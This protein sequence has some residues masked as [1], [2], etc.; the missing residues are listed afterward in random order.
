[1]YLPIVNVVTLSR[2]VRRLFPY[3]GPAVEDIVR[4]LLQTQAVNLR[5]CVG[6]GKT[7][8]GLLSAMIVMV[9][10]RRIDRILFLA[11]TNG[12]V[13]QTRA[14]SLNEIEGYG[15]LPQFQP[16][17][18]DVS[19]QVVRFL[20]NRDG[21]AYGTEGAAPVLVTTYHAFRGNAVARQLAREL[22][23][24]L[25]ILVDEGFHAPD[26]RNEE[27]TLIAQAVEGHP[28]VLRLGGT[29]RPDRQAIPGE[30]VAR[31]LPA[32]M[33]EGFTPHPLEVETLEVEGD[34]SRDA[35]ADF[36]GVPA[37][38]RAA[39]ARIIEHHERDGRPRALLRIKAGL[40]DERTADIAGACMNLMSESG[41]TYVDGTGTDGGERLEEYLEEREGCN[42]TGERAPYAIL[43]DFVIV[44]RRADEGLDLVSRSHLYLFGIPRSLE[45][46]EQL[47]GR[48]LRLRID[49]HSREPL[50]AG[51][52]ERWLNVSKVVFVVPHNTAEDVSR[53][54]LQATGYISGMSAD[55]AMIRELRV[56]DGF[57]GRPEPGPP[58]TL[59]VDPVRSRRIGEIYVHVLA[60]MLACPDTWGPETSWKIT[61]HQWSRMILD[62]IAQV[63]TLPETAPER[64]LVG[65]FGEQDLPD[66]QKVIAFRRAQAQTEHRNRL[67]EY[68]N[69]RRHEG[70]AFNDRLDEAVSRL[71]D[72]FCDETLVN[73]SLH[74]LTAEAI[75]EFGRRLIDAVCNPNMPRTHDEVCV[76]V[77][78]FRALHNGQFPLLGDSDPESGLFFRNYDSALR[79]G[80]IEPS[81]EGGLGEL[82]VR[83]DWIA[84]LHR[85][86]EEIDAY[87]SGVDPATAG[88]NT[89]RLRSVSG[90]QQQYQREPEVV[91]FPHAWRACRDATTRYET[92]LEADRIGQGL[93][94]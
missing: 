71:L 27:A 64:R 19:A 77:E 37:N 88:M 51:Y 9:M 89:S 82:F 46:L 21:N 33:L 8:I 26:G 34:V 17:A 83:P 36:F 49:Y 29:D 90:I 78:R 30:L 11:P 31:P 81:L 12:I 4:I 59:P 50:Y 54:L 74:S 63:R 94:R 62:Y 80:T 93:P 13:R 79:H 15:T 20:Q 76:R 61:G 3:Q 56:N 42:P 23:E 87:R 5:F 73:D 40:D 75:E 14:Y 18:S 6:S 28:M 38:Y 48:T 65:D 35:D 92:I 55:I 69:E 60:M 24:R 57:G 58:P 85:I 1:V 41:L 43:E 10:H 39:I 2:P 22:G 44:V 52:P 86:A 84:R 53:V 7:L 68:M 66:I 16:A 70:R 72:E 91:Y 25:L 45:L 47:T 32:H 67:A